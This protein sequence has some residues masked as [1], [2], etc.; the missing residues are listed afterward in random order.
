[1]KKIKVNALLKIKNGKLEAFKAL[2][3]QFISKVRDEEPDTLNYDWFLNEATME[4]MVLENYTDS[5]AVL[6]HV[7]NVNELLQKLMELADLKL[8]IFGNPSNEL[9]AAIE[10][11]GPKVFPYYSG[12]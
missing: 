8:E 5:D 12:A 9:S 1:M 2:V 4:C 6:S 10:P 11:F 3:P 7:A